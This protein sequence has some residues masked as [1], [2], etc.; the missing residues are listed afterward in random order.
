MKAQVVLFCFLLHPLL[1][2]ASTV[3]N[4]EITALYDL[5]VSLQGE[6]WLWRSNDTT[7]FVPYIREHLPDDVVYGQPWNFTDPVNESEP[8]LPGEGRW[9]GV[10]CTG[11]LKHIDGLYLPLKLLNGTLPDSLCE[12][13]ALKFL[14]LGGNLIR[15]ELPNC[16][17]RLTQLDEFD[18]HFNHLTGRIPDSIWNMTRLRWFSVYHNKMTGELS[19]LIGNMVNLEMLSLATN[20]FSGQLPSELGFLQTVHYAPIGNIKDCGVA[21]KYC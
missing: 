9:Q 19:P 13:F 14:Y 3:S 18:F 10:N 15:G 1:T 7:V 20:F 16:M 17:S 6:N 4:V 11:D 12:M 5:Y 21:I 2:S 8:C